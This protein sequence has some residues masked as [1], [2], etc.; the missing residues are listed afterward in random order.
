MPGDPDSYYT[1]RELLPV[2]MMADLHKARIVITNFHAFKRRERLEISAGGRRWIT[3]DTSRVALALARA[4][5]MGARHPY[6][7]LADS[8]DGQ[9]KEAEITR[10]APSG[11]PTG[12]NIRHGFVYERV[13]HITLK[14][15]A[16]NTEIDVIWDTFQKKL[17]PLRK[18]LNQALKTA[19]EEWE[20]PREP[21]DAWPDEVKK[22]HGDWW[23]QRIKQQ[24][25][26]D[27]AIAARADHEFLYDR[28]YE[29]RIVFQSLTPW[30]GDLIC[31]EGRYLEDRGG[32]GKEKQ[33]AIF[34]G[35]E[36][37]TV[38]RPDLV[39]AAR[40]RPHRRQGHQPPGR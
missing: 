31:A 40:V 17:E 19:W 39:Q 28:P 33:A 20:I 8:R 32:N 5:I 35:P 13:P 9:L 25:E 15:I 18:A 11:H 34:I 23:T 21:D 6:Y 1:T 26:I 7:L 12:D 4:R 27:A 30:P 16:N 22:I 14:A 24:K 36:S 3:M 29:D 2:D 38:S 37:G 10:R